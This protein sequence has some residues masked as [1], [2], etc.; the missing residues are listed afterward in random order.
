MA[1]ENASVFLVQGGLEMLQACNSLKEDG[2]KVVGKTG[3]LQIALEK[4]PGLRD[5]GIDVVVVGEGLRFGMA[6]VGGGRVAREV[7]ELVPDAMIVEY[8]RRNEG[9]GD[10]RVAKPFYRLRRVDLGKEI[11][12]L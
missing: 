8:T 2:H 12:R 10:H 1:P 5:D 9:F 3:S 6:D 7:R 4:I 11:T